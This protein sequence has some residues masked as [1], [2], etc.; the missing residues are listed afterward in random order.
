M[1]SFYRIHKK[2]AEMNKSYDVSVSAHENR[3]SEE[4]LALINKYSQ[5]ELTADELFTFSVIL[6][7]NEIDRDFE[8]FTVDALKKLAKL[9]VGKTAIK[10]HSMSSED[11]SART[12]KTEV[13]TDN[14]KLNSLGEP[15]TYLKAYCYMPRISKN[16]DLIAEIQSGIKKEVSVGCSVKKCICSVCG[17]DSRK[18]PCAHRRGKSY[19]GKLC[20]YELSES[21]DAYEW[22]FV[23]VPAQKNAGV[24][25][26]FRN[27]KEVSMNELIETIKS[28]PDSLTLDRAQTKELADF[29]CQLEEKAADGEQYR[30]QLESDTVKQFAFAFE[31]LSDTYTRNIC[32]TL[33]TEDLKQLNLA[34][35][36]SREKVAIPQLAAEA[37]KSDKDNSQFRF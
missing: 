31:K 27:N 37:E 18:T 20:Y 30:S 2:E 21:D 33:S 8:R 25:K 11:Q 28:I 19:D 1:R 24:T 4:D 7:D 23:A 12:Y 22:S 6:C 15:Y 29:I 36:D 9:F 3:L 13:V 10:N 35:H 5:K 16:E 34:L 26:S 17:R 32:K 14:E